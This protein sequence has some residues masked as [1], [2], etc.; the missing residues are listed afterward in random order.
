MTADTPN[1]RPAAHPPEIVLALNVGRRD[2]EVLTG[3]DFDESMWVAASLALDAL[4]AELADLRA[5][6]DR[7]T[8]AA[9]LAEKNRRFEEVRANRA[10]AQMG[11]V[12]ALARR[13]GG[14]AQVEFNVVKAVSAREEAP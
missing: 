6:H 7:L 11:D 9:V 12:L 10:E 14:Q 4:V 13:H 2:N 1:D 5:E 8:A 3:R